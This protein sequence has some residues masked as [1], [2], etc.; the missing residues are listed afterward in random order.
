MNII[1]AVHGQDKTWEKTQEGEIENASFVVEKERQIELPI[2]ARR[3]EKIPPVPN[4]QM[5]R[6][7]LPYS[8]SLFYPEMNI[9]FIPNRA[10]K[11]KDEPLDKLYGGTVN[12]GFGNYVTPYLEVDYF[13]KRE[14][15]YLIGVN[16]E[17]LSSRNGPVDKQNSGNGYSKLKFTSKFFNS[18]FTSDVS[19]QYKRSFYHFYGYPEN[20]PV[21]EDSIRRKFDH[22]ALQGH[23]GNND[24][25][26]EFDYDLKF[27]F[28]YFTDNFNSRE[29]DISL[30]LKS[31]IVLDDD[32]Q[33]LL[34]GD[35]NIMNYKYES[36]L[37]RNLIR[38]KPSIF[39]KYNEFDLTAGLNFVFQNDTLNSRGSVLLYPMIRVD[40]HL[41]DYFNMY[42]KF[43][44]DLEKVT[45][46]D[47]AYENPYTVPGAPV[48]HRNKKFGLN[49]GI[50]GNILNV[51]NFTAGF[52][53]SEYKDM[54]FYQNDSLNVSTFN[55]L[56]EHQNTSFSNIYGELVFSRIK[57]YHVSL[58][59]DYFKYS[60]KQL[61]VPWHK[62]SYQIS[63]H[64]N[65]SLYEKIVFGANIYFMGG[66][67][68]FDWENDQT[69]RLDPIVD[70]N[71]DVNYRFSDQLGA[72]IK[73]DNILGKNYERYYRYPVRS[74][75]VMIGAS[76]N[77]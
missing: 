16:A 39:Y 47:I 73:F 13:N 6:Q 56:Y 12:L 51:L 59:A 11:L 27:N 5:T 45:F 36:N 68:A 44:G 60:T 33:F 64:M 75:Q 65:Y 24:Q 10:L 26:N 76:V 8:F 1:S 38:I 46:R 43:D 49:W 3:F 35:I 37:N 57:Q 62:P 67:Q 63:S 7:V 25:E 48:L 32:L 72:F 53:L 29:S 71:L 22:I 34:D 21:V 42:L 40:Y 69:V 52:S 23:L 31:G 15:K 55:L 41:N 58:R 70:L 20:I 18:A 74:I 2:E 9:L 54:Y 17:H 19:A 61:D 77:F 50:D 4:D 28:D 30:G 66:I 14:N